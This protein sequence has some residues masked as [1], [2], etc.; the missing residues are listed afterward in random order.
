LLKTSAL[1]HEKDMFFLTD[2][3]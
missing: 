1:K 3:M 2:L